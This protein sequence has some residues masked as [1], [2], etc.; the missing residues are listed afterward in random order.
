[1]KSPP[2]V[3]GLHFPFPAASSHQNILQ[4]DGEASEQ[5]TEHDHQARDAADLDGRG[6]QGLLAITRPAGQTR[7][8]AAAARR[9][10]RGRH[11]RG[12]CRVDAGR[13]LRAARVVLPAVAGAGV[14]LAAGGDAL[15]TPLLADEVGQRQRVLGDVGLLAVAA[16]AAV[17]QGR[18][19][20]SVDIGGARRNQLADDGAGAKLTAAPRLASGQRNAVRV[21]DIVGLGADSEE[22]RGCSQDGVP[23]RRHYYEAFEI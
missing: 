17:G 14:V 23:D 1:M 15:V 21:D 9:A 10:G 8:Q 20:A 18:G 16:D 2:I 6:R 7:V 22:G 13:V 12:G 4:H 11:G 19:I 5:A 3:F